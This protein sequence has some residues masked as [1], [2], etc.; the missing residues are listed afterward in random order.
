MVNVNKT[1]N[2]PLNSK[3]N[4]LDLDNLIASRTNLGVYSQAAVDAAIAAAIVA[5][6]PANGRMPVRLA[7]TAMGLPAYTGGGTG[8][9]TLTGV[10]ALMVDGVALVN[11]DRILA[12]DAVPAN[13]RDNGIYVVSGVGATIV[14]TRALDADST[15]EVPL[16][17]FVFVNEG[18][19]A[20]AGFVIITAPAAINVNPLVFTR[21][22]ED[23]AQT[24]AGI[25]LVKVGNQISVKKQRIAIPVGDYS[26]ASLDAGQLVNGKLAISA[27]GDNIE[28]PSAA[29]VFANIGSEE[30]SIKDES[31]NA[32]E[33]AF[34][35]VET[36]R[37]EVSKIDDADSAAALT[38]GP[39]VVGRRYNIL[40]LNGADDFTNVGFV[41]VGTPFIATGAAPTVWAGLTPVY[42]KEGIKITVPYGNL[43][44]YTDGVNWFTV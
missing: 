12:K 6:N 40:A 2:K 4:L 30:I 23:G 35:R 42:E 19:Q 20:S 8:T 27:F 11:G 13:Q 29:L 7:T 15:G 18:S 17:M 10:A 24:L 22:T 44:V 1:S 14:L 25:G 28:L 41:A 3:K 34:I 43:R 33:V 16:G 37:T 38:A 39:L 9:L 26:I 21:F 31:G 36:K 5:A 32:S